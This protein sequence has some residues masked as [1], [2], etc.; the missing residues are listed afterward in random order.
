MRFF[1]KCRYSSCPRNAQ[2]SRVKE[3]IRS[4]SD[5]TQTAPSAV[6]SAG[7]NATAESER[8]RADDPAGS[9]LGG[10]ARSPTA[11][12]GRVRRVTKACSTRRQAHTRRRSTPCARGWR[13][14]RQ[15]WPPSQTSPSASPFMSRTTL[16]YFGRLSVLPQWRKKGIGGAL[17]TT[18]SAARGNRR[19]RRPAR[20]PPAAAASHRAIRAPGIS[21]HET[22]DA[23]RLRA[24]D[25]HLHG[26][27][28]LS[29]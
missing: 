26:E 22:H 11:D 17:S 13:T 5:K 9:R 28:V 21:D 14:A 15:S 7:I 29:F 16:L 20:R 25:I 24:A 27:K 19:G 23:H 4:P 10:C 1:S 18:L 8:E 3:A 2:M 12:A 6:P